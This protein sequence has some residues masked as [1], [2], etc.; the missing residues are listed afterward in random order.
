[1]KKWLVLKGSKKNKFQFKP[2]PV[3]VMMGPKCAI[4]K[5]SLQAR[6]EVE[7]VHALS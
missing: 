4:A 3:E 7:D 2:F 5:A 1:M 6:P